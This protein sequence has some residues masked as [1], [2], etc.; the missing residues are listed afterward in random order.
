MQLHHALAL[1]V[2]VELTLLLGSGVLV[3]LVFRDKIVHVGLSLSELHLVHALTSVPVQESLSAEHSS[4]LLRYS[5]PDL[6]D[7]SGVTNEGGGHLEALGGDI[8]NRSLNVVG[9]PLNEVRRVLVDDVQ[10]L[11]VNLLGRHSASEHAGAGEV[12]SVS[13]VSSA[14][15][16][17][18]I[19]LLLSE[20]R[21]SEGSVLLGSSRSEGSEAH[22]EEVETREGNH[23]NSEL[24]EIAV[25]LAGEAQ[26]AGGAADSSRDQVVKIAVGGGGELEGSEADIVQGLVIKGEALIG[27]LDQLVDREGGVVGLDDGIRHLGGGDDGVGRHDS[28]GVLLSDL[29]DQEGAHTSTGSTT[30]GVG[31]LETLEAV[32]GLSLL[33]DNIEDRVNQLST[34]SVVALG[35]VVTGSGLAEHE[36]IRAEE[37]A[38]R[39]STDRVHGTGLEIHEDGTGDIASA[40]GLVEVHVDSL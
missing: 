4:E 11:L 34:L 33:A 15:H 28:V 36:V 30:H 8:A 38:E 2:L 27:V 5:L 32:A 37:L 23:V 3:L 12:S 14:H 22:H 20:L 10:H 1:S 7:G 18:G 17:L 19:K 26:A 25:Q 16:V 6:L 40:G 13:G 29:R 31:E 24:A 21:N 39:T 35:P 9:D